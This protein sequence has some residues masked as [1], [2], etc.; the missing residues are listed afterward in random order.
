MRQWGMAFGGLDTACT[1]WLDLSGAGLTESARSLL[2]RELGEFEAVLGCRVRLGPRSGSD[3]VWCVRALPE[4]GAPARLEWHADQAVLVSSADTPAQVLS[5]FSLLHVLARSPEAH[6]SLVA[7]STPVEAFRAI[8]DEIVHTYPYFTLR[9]LDPA[10]WA[11]RR[12]DDVPTTWESF[13]PWAQEWVAELGDA[14][15]SVVDRDAHGQ[16]PPWT[17]RLEALG[18]VLDEVPDTSA[19]YEAGVRTGWA[20]EVDDPDGW[21]RRTGATPVQR[22]QVAARRALAVPAGG[23]VFRARDPRTGDGVEWFE[24]HRE[25][26]L[27][28]VVA[29]RRDGDD[30]HVRLSAFDERM[31][32]EDVFDELCRESTVTRRLVLDLRGNTGGSLVQALDLRDRFMRER[33]CVGSAAF[34]NGHGELAAAQQRWAEPSDRPRWAGRL[35]IRVDAMTYSAAEDFVLGLQGLPHVRVVGERTG[36]GSGRPRTV[37]IGPGLDLRVSTAI[38]Y[39]RAGNPVEYHGIRPDGDLVLSS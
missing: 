12:P 6:V 10:R 35:V 8:Q 13:T 27:S 23:R 32:V 1:L 2:E 14:H 36:G 3:P 24:P 33:T 29:V 18:V 17:G 34:T 7:P 37:P 31:P 38:T 25:R 4:A 22:R 26:R 19:A 30:V 9:G 15:T 39:D 11:V 28:D 21:M 20:V 16:A 5:T